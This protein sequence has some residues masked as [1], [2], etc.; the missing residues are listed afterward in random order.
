ML[1]M[2]QTTSDSPAS[3]RQTVEEGQ[4]QDRDFLLTHT[5]LA[6]SSPVSA[7]SSIRLVYP[8]SRVPHIPTQPRATIMSNHHLF[9]YY[10]LSQIYG[11]TVETLN[12]TFRPVRQRPIH[13]QL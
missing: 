13:S 5:D 7:P 3:D 2:G 4:C 8:C 11:I 6:R 12:L 9:N 1:T 10:A